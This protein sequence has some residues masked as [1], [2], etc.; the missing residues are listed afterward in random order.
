ML[1]EL[2]L[3]RQE[4]HTEPSYTAVSRIDTKFQ[5][6]SMWTDGGFLIL[7]FAIETLLCSAPVHPLLLRLCTSSLPLADQ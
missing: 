3:E 7:Q 2:Y 1:S 5:R 4:R 6:H